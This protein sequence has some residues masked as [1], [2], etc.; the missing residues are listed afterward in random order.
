MTGPFFISR[1]FQQTQM[2]TSDA[3]YGKKNTARKNLAP[4]TALFRISAK[5]SAHSSVSG[6]VITV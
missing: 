2:A 1:K 4:F 5:P 3:T 6:T